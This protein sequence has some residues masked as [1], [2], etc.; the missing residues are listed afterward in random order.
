MV[1]EGDWLVRR[2]LSVPDLEWTPAAFPTIHKRPAA[3]I[4]ADILSIPKG[5][6]H[7]EG[8]AAFIRF[9][10]QPEQIE[11]LALGHGK[12]SP[13]RQ[14]SER[15]LAQHGNSKLWMLREIL[16]S[17]QLFHDPRVPGWMNYRSRIKQAFSCIWSEGQPP[18]QALAT[19]EDA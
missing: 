19:I 12:I 11:R 15:F 5:A 10:M 16:S 14:R 8:A 17:A 2:L 13:L 6:R 4:V 18:A 3:L 7:P 9:A 1:F